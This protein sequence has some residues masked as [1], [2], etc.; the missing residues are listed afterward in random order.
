M[1]NRR[2][3]FS[4]LSSVFERQGDVVF[5]GLQCVINVCGEDE[6]RAKLHAVIESGDAIETPLEKNAYYKRIAALL[7]Q[8]LPFLEYGFWDLI[9]KAG[10][11]ESEFESWVTGVTASMATE[12]EEMGEAIDEMFRMSSDKSY[13]VVTLLF[14]LENTERLTPFFELVR[15]IDEEDPHTKTAYST[16][17]DSLAYIDFEYSHADASFVMPGSAEDGLSWED[18]KGEGW[19]YLA[20]VMGV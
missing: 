13:V 14:L 5:F 20:P 10:E 2:G 8:D 3:F 12:D 4:K 18:I 15:S 19:E 17:I 9:A 6:L 11:A 7:R 1:Y 16:L